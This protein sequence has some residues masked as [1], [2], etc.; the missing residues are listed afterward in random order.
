MSDNW[1]RLLDGHP[2]GDESSTPEFWEQYLDEHP[3][4]LHRLLADIYQATYG[5]EKPPTLDDLW[6]MFATP[7]FSTEPFGPAL[8]DVLGDRSVRWLAQQVGTSHT[9]LLNYISGR[10][11]IVSVHD[12]RGSMQRIESI[13]RVLRVHPSYFVEWRRLWVLSLID[14]AFTAQ[15]ALSVGLF[16]RFSGFEK[17]SHER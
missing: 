1:Q 8:L 16:R 17:A 13:A 11:A 3:E 4:V 10:R 9:Q 15:P 5:S 12:H 2:H 14:S 7:R 6:E